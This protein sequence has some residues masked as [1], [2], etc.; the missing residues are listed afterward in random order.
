MRCTLLGVAVV[1]AAQRELPELVDAVTA[2][3]LRAHVA[4]LAADELQGRDTATDGTR[5]A[6]EYLAAALAGYGVLP[7]GDDGTFLQTV[8]LE[9]VRATEPVVLVGTRVDGGAFEGVDGLEI[10]VRRSGD[11]VGPLAV[12][13]VE[14][15]APIPEPDEALALYFPS[16]SSAALERLAAAGRPGGEGFGLLLLEGRR[17]MGRR[18]REPDGRARLRAPGRRPAQV[19]V[20]AGLMEEFAAGQVASVELQGGLTVEPAACQNVVGRIPGSAR[21]DEVVV[22]SAHYDHVGRHADP[23]AEDSVYNGADDDASGCAAVVEIAGALAREGGLDRT[24]VVL[25]ATGEERGL[26]GTEHYLEHPVRPLAQTVLNLNFEMVGRPDALV[27]AGR[28][29]LTGWERSNL[30]PAFAA[31]GLAVSPDRRPDQNFFRRSDN[32]AFAVR[33]IVAQTLS[34]YGLHADYHAVTDEASTLD[35]DHMERALVDALGAVRMTVGSALTPEWSPGG[36]PA[37]DD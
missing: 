37:E 30:G 2:D 7:A 14:A 16:S 25:L 28:L 20:N 17:K 33:G 11:P 1:V 23:D 15:D 4:F 26:L 31:A 8:P 35:Y 6:A 21:A 5:R 29:W 27:G 13:V 24:V 34:S 32:W 3:E 19:R 36:N 10:L 12:A 9:R 18:V 22:L